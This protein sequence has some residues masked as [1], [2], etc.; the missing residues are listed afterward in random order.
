M[1]E[2]D[3]LLDHVRDV[4]D[5]PRAGVVFKDLTPAMA[6]PSVFYRTVSELADR[7]APRRPSVVLG[8]ESRGFIYG[9]PVA[10]ALGV[11][12]VPVRKP[13]KLP[14]ETVQQTFELEYG[15]DAV[16]IH[17]DAIGEGDRVAVVDDVL[18]TGGTAAATIELVER[19]GG[20]VAGVSV[21]LEL[22]FLDPRS[23]LPGTPVHS[24]LST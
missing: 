3:W 10:G 21:L 2:S 8:I 19:C 22:G 20:I 18:A 16:E 13:G 11:G 12:F 4:A 24:L 17:A 7:L 15:V 5:F 14:R 6:D 9:A 1:G 23:K